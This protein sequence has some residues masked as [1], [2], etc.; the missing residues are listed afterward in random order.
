[1][2]RLFDENNDKNNAVLNQSINF[3]QETNID[4]LGRLYTEK[5]ASEKK[6]DIYDQ[7]K[8]KSAH[9]YSSSK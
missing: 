8:L 9:K 3:D 6:N 5:L 1:V 2:P 4:N 7:Y